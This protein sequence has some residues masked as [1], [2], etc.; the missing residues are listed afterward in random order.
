M[1]DMVSYLIMVYNTYHANNTLLYIQGLYDIHPA[2][3]IDGL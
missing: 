1:Q 3:M 2:S